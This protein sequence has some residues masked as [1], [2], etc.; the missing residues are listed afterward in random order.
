MD[1]RIIS[2]SSFAI[3]LGLISM[4]HFSERIDEIGTYETIELAYMLASQVVC[5]LG[6]IG[7]AIGL[8]SSI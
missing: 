4:F 3:I 1:Y 6:F 2:L 8:K 7:I 5:G